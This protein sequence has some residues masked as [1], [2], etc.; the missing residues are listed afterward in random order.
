MNAVLQ[1]WY[2]SE[3]SLGHEPDEIDNFNSRILGADDHPVLKLRGG[4]HRT[5]KAID[6]VRPTFIALGRV[7]PRTTRRGA[8]R[9]L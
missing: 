7:P 3:R 1:R 6:G 5:R 2:A 4:R 9:I 8:S